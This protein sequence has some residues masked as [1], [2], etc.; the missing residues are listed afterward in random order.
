MKCIVCYQRTCIGTIS[1]CNS[2]HMN[3]CIIC[4]N[5]KYCTVEGYCVVCYQDYL[6]RMDAKMRISS[7]EVYD[8][9]PLRKKAK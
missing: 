5:I 1:V 6:Y 9:E 3:K 4:K 8:E 7:D 2:C